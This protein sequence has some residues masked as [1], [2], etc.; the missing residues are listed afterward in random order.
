[1]PAI[2]P[3]SSA[4]HYHRHEFNAVPKLLFFFFLILMIPQA[5]Y[6]SHDQAEPIRPP[7]SA[8]TDPATESHRDSEP[9]TIQDLVISEIQTQQ[10]SR[11]RRLETAGVAALTGGM[12][13][14]GA[15]AGGPVTALIAGTSTL[16]I[17]IMLK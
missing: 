16:A 12:L 1:L 10:L 8:E 2:L 4:K 9:N 15:V 5:G 11:L 14:L 17:Y 6:G 3:I 13:L 7:T